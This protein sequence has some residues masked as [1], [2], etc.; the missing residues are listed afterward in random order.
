M[1]AS[2]LDYISLEK[3]YA[4]HTV[5][6]YRNDLEAFQTFYK[7]HYETDE[8]ENAN[9]SEIRRWIVELVNNGLSNRT[10][11]RKISALNGY[12]KFLQRRNELD[13][14]P[15]VGHKALKVAKRL[16]VP[17]SENE[18][19][20]VLSGIETDDF[21]AIRNKML[22]ELL[23]T[24]G[25]RRDE[26]IELKE[27]GVDISNN[28][29]KVLGKRN[30]ER[31]IPILAS[32]KKTLTMYIKAKES[33]RLENEYLLV[34]AKGNKLYG[35]LVYRIINNYFSRVSTKVKKSPHVITA[36]ICHTFV[37]R[38]GRFEFG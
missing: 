30:K 16:Q 9:Y 25:M 8:I 12:Y 3:Q 22:I 21:E 31:Y 19:D 2:F 6:A 35:T 18:I 27:S 37:K 38:R 5:L 29:I 32:L 36:F 15:L 26:L 33:L 13:K 7:E 24:T 4:S 11:N 28:T 10:I 23:Y 14:N 17:F 34:T 1:L 20:D